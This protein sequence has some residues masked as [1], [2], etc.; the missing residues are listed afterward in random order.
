MAAFVRRQFFRTKLADG[1][2]AP[3]GSQVHE[4]ADTAWYARSCVEAAREAQFRQ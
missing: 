2:G 1:I 3:V 4:L